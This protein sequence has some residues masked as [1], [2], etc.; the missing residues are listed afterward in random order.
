MSLDSYLHFRMKDGARNA[1]ET[2]HVINSGPLGFWY[3]VK[4]ANMSQL[5]N[6]GMG[7]LFTNL[8][9]IINNVVYSEGLAAQY[10]T[11]YKSVNEQLFLP[12]DIP[13]TLARALWSDITFGMADKAN[14]GYWLDA[15]SRSLYSPHAQKLGVYFGLT[16]SQLSAILDYLQQ[17]MNSLKSIVFD[18]YYCKDGSDC[19]GFNLAARQMMTSEITNKTPPVKGVLPSE[20]LCGKNATCEGGMPEISIYYEKVFRKDHPEQEFA[21]L[22][23]SPELGKRWFK[24][25]YPELNRN[26]DSILH[27]GNLEALYNNG[28]LY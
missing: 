20:S 5:F 3:Q 13:E 27:F 15:A 7:I 4:T 21:N 11:D 18:N 19:N 1:N 24:H 10:L 28:T 14:F 26:E 6:Q 16:T 2:I 25:S 22:T 17:A 23:F 12:A 9:T 8:E